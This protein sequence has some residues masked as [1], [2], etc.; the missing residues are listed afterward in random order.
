MGATMQR[1]EPPMNNNWAYN[2]VLFPPSISLMRAASGIV[3]METSWYI[4]MTHPDNTILE[5]NDLVIAGKA[6]DT[7]VLSIDPSKIATV[8]DMKIRFLRN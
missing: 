8:T 7:E 6:T 3:L 4:V 1:I 2:S 5:L